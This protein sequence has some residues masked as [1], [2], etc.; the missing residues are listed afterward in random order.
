MLEQNIFVVGSKV[1]RTKERCRSGEMTEP[2]MDVEHES[3]LVGMDLRPVM[4]VEHRAEPMMELV[5]ESQEQGP[6]L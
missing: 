2:E 5:G 4:D 6:S 1:P 3:K